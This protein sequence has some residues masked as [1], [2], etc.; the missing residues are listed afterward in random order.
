MNAEE[1]FQK[2]LQP[3]KTA[4]QTQKSMDQFVAELAQNEHITQQ[5]SWISSL[6]PQPSPLHPITFEDF[7][8][9]V[10]DTE[11]RQERIAFEEHC[12][13]VDES[14]ELLERQIT[15][16]LTFPSD[17]VDLHFILDTIQSLKKSILGTAITGD[18]E[19]EA[20]EQRHRN[21]FWGRIEGIDPPARIPLA[22]RIASV[23][24][25]VR[26]N[27]K[28]VQLP[29]KQKSANK[30]QIRTGVY[31]F[32][33]VDSSRMKIDVI[34]VDA[35]T[36]TYTSFQREALDFQI[37]RE[38]L[39]SHCF[40]IPLDTRSEGG[41]KIWFMYE[42][43]H[44]IPFTQFFNSNTVLAEQNP[45]FAHWRTRIASALVDIS[46]YCSKQLLVPLTAKNIMVS[47]DGDYI[48]IVDAEWGAD[49]DLENPEEP[50]AVPS[51]V[52]I[53]EDAIPVSLRGPV[54]KSIIEIASSGEC[55]IFDIIRHPYFRSLQPISDIR[56]NMQASR[57]TKEGTLNEDA[58]G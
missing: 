24:Q 36:S 4:I 51:L 13:A 56:V 8:R 22:S 33:A 42:G 38:L 19:A 31:Q 28:K 43:I 40:R 37:A 30:K 50:L 29:V 35:V 3:G 17:V 32:Q 7:R 49:K 25:M 27:R 26:Q 12:E 11:F 55:T 14:L 21:F 20:T 47:S 6:F 23:G 1:C 41:D 34:E 45:L 58:D 10:I 39:P 2:A 18:S 15:K 46:M 5:D 54:L 57:S 48:A 44:Y 16:A 9:A 52:S 53:V